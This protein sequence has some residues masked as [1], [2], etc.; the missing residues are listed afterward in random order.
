MAPLKLAVKVMGIADTGDAA[1]IM[2]AVK[3]NTDNSDF[4]SPSPEFEA[5]NFPAV[6]GPSF[7]RENVRRTKS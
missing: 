7:V 2:T 1:S 3:V 4:I 5:V 6:A